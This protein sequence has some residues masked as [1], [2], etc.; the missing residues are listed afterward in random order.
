MDK[1]CFQKKDPKMSNTV[2]EKTLRRKMEF[3]I[4]AEYISELPEMDIDYFEDIEQ[5]ED[6]EDFMLNF[7]PP[8]W[9]RKSICS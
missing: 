6:P 5:W 7:N 1:K 9:P 8:V 4:T 3:Y 2:N